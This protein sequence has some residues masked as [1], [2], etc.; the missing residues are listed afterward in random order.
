MP[1]K[2]ETSGY[3]CARQRPNPTESGNKLPRTL[4]ASR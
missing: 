3:G 2:F 4:L 1:A